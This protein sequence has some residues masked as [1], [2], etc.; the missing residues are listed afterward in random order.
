MHSADST[1]KYHRDGGV[2][3]I[4]VLSLKR[5]V[6]DG[7]I[8][9]SSE[10]VDDLFLAVKENSDSDTI[11][12]SIETVLKAEYSQDAKVYPN[13][14]LDGPTIDVVVELQKN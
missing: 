1:R 9:I 6:E 10:E 3:H 8:F 4:L 13:G 14:R 5:E 12:K 7:I 2:G 11:R